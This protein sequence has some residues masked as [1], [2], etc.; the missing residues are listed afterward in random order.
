MTC[1]NSPPFTP[2]ELILARSRAFSRGDFAFIFDS[3]HS[4]SNF[5]R[6]FAERKEYLQFARTGPGRDY[7]IRSCMILDEFVGA[8][9]SQ[10]VFLLEMEFH[11]RAQRYVELAWLRREDDAWRYHRGQKITEDE[12]PEDPESLRVADFAGLDPSTIF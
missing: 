2:S 12:L 4:D 10:V 9:E 5:R 1:D 8:A 7:Q 6:Q 11:G 3:Y